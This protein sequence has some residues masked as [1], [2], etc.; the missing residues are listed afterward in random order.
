MIFK[1]IPFNHQS[2]AFERYKDREYF[3]LFCDMGTGKSKI[4]LDIAAYK[5]INNQINSVLLIAPN[6]V[7]TQWSNEQIKLHFAADE[8]DIT[9]NTFIWNSEL[10]NRGYYKHA[11]AKFLSTKKEKEVRFFIVNVEAFQSDSV[12]PFVAEFVHSSIPLIGIDEATRIKEPSAKRTKVILR[13]NKYGQR[14]IMTGTPATKSPFNLWAQMEFLKKNYFHCS[15]FIFQH[16]YGLMMKDS[17]PWNGKMYHT[18]INEKTFK[19]V[20]DKLKKITEERNGF[21]M[22]DDYLTISVMYGISIE[23]VKYIM[24]QKEYTTFQKLDELK[25]Y[26]AND[27]YAVK[28][29]DCLDLPEKIYERIDVHLTKEQRQI[30]DNLKTELLAQYQDQ[31]ITVVNKIVLTTRLMQIVGGFFPYKV[32]KEKIIGSEHIPYMNAETMLIGKTNIKLEAIKADLEEIGNEQII[33]WA[34]FKA[35]LKYIYNE[36]NKIYTCCLYYGDIRQEQREEIKKDF[37]AGKYK[38][39]IGNPQVAGFGLNLQNATL[40]YYFSN[41]YR[42]EDRLQAED[43]SHR[44]GVKTNVTYKDIVAK[45]TVDEKIYLSIKEGKDLNNFFKDISLKDLLN[46]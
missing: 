42:T 2:I 43:R 8:N 1:T 21:L 39:F 13:L 38:I 15:Y 10:I 46:D 40:Q 35:E 9:Y 33:I 32:E 6:N 5:F 37:V 14:A 11:L 25:A 28:K 34:H 20:K 19:L 44:I 16:R 22:P 26:I 27:I 23:N 7:H 45:N 24:N 17:N 30:Y 3:G 31:E 12:I 36:L 4:F 18:L 41:S 29:E